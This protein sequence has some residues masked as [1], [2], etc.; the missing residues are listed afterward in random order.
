MIRCIGQV[1]EGGDGRYYITCR[2]AEGH[3]NPFFQEEGETDWLGGGHHFMSLVNG[4]ANRKFVRDW[5]DKNCSAP[6]DFH[7]HATVVFEDEADAGLF[8]MMF[9]NDKPQA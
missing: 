3:M 9:K 1:R 2:G 5:M 4:D 6:A 7:G 8:W